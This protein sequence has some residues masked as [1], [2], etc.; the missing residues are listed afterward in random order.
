MNSYPIG[1]TI[2]LT[3]TPFTNLATNQPFDPTTVTLRFRDPTGVETA[4][5][6]ADLTHVGTGVFSYTLVANIS[7]QWTYAFEGSGNCAVRGPDAQFFVT[8]SKLIPG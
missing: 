3:S 2:T 7:G 4:V 1:D 5:T 6:T 8:R